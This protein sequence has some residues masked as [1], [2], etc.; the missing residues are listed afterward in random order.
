[1]ANPHFSVFMQGD[2]ELR[3]RLISGLIYDRGIGVKWLPKE[4]VAIDQVMNEVVVIP[5]FVVV[6]DGPPSDPN[7]ANYYV[8]YRDYIKNV[9]SSE[10]YSTWPDSTL[11]A[12]ILAIMSF[13][14]N[15]VYTEWYRNKG[16]NFTITT[17][18]ILWKIFLP[19]TNFWS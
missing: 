12:N 10:I 13:T 9:A 8:R 19:Y 14:L 1:M 2:F 4:L 15:W 16:Y 5:E 3:E 7:A 17:S 18:E 11:R 6:H